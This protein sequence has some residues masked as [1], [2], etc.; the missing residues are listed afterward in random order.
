MGK[1][2]KVGDVI[3]ATEDITSWLENVADA[4]EEG[5]VLG[6]NDDGSLQVLFRTAPRPV[7]VELEEADKV[8]SFKVKAKKLG[9]GM[10]VWRSKEGLWVKL[11]ELNID[12][13]VVYFSG[14]SKDQDW[15]WDE[16]PKDDLVEVKA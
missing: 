11:D 2:I 9:L 5:F 1:K 14:Y 15:F 12:G 6:V 3:T 13:D 16:T 4:G 7:R 10:K 8:K